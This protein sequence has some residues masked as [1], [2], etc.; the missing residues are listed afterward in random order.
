MASG[1]STVGRLLAR[2]LGRPL[3]DSD[4]DMAAD[5]GVSARDMAERQGV[6]ALHR[7]EAAHLL[8][9]LAG[10]PP[11]VV[12]AAASAI[13]DAT[14]RDALAANLVVWLRIP[15]SVAVR[16]QAETTHGHRPDLGV[17]ALE[18]AALRA[19]A[20]FSVADVIVDAADTGPAGTVDA[21]LARL[22]RELRRSRPA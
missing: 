10:G 4:D 14:C 9:S 20:Y 18:Q 11:A 1:K 8:R 6:A 7:W 21:V 17:Q 16:R 22:P 5:L 15:L 12:A 13:D 3:R 19:P 2:R